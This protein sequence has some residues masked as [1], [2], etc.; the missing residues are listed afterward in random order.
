MR[1]PSEI[2]REEKEGK[3]RGERERDFEVPV[4]DALGVAV[5]DSFY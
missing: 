1:G 3:E 5:G 2:E 4:V